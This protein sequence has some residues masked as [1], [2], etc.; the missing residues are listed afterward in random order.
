ME[1]IEPVEEVLLNDY[2]VGN[3][4][5]SVTTYQDLQNAANVKPYLKYYIDRISVASKCEFWKKTYILIINDNGNTSQQCMYDGKYRF[6]FMNDLSLQRELDYLKATS[7]EVLNQMH[8][9]EFCIEDRR[10]RRNVND[11]IEY[12][13]KIAN[14]ID[15]MFDIYKN[16][17]I[18]KFVDYNNNFVS[19]IYL[20]T[21]QNLTSKAIKKILNLNIVAIVNFSSSGRTLNDDFLQSLTNLEEIGILKKNNPQ[22]N[23]DEAVV[24]FLQQVN[25][26]SLIVNFLE[27]KFTYSQQVFRNLLTVSE[28]KNLKLRLNYHSPLRALL[29]EKSTSGSDIPYNFFHSIIELRISFAK[30]TTF[31]AYL[32]EFPNLETLGMIIELHSQCKIKLKKITRKGFLERHHNMDN[33]VNL[34]KLKEVTIFVADVKLNEKKEVAD[35]YQIL[36][37]YIL[38]NLPKEIKRLWIS[39]SGCLTNEMM[40][41][42]RTRHQLLEA[43]S[44][45]NVRFAKYDCLVDLNSLKFLHLVGTER[46]QIPENVEHLIVE[47][48]AERFNYNL[49]NNN[50]AIKTWNVDETTFPSLRNYIFMKIDLEIRVNIYFKSIKSLCFGQKMIQKAQKN[51]NWKDFFEF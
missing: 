49:K 48:E 39:Y 32:S 21:I 26:K 44:L 40:T 20:D 37:T 3:I 12:G 22:S 38:R 33:V 17:S 9:I 25:I 14:F 42:I 36:L 1:Q 5:K 24:S 27:F 13:R 35:V 23:N 29:R 47:Y 4:M 43:L 45:R 51:W 34:T 7:S 18:L 8:E 31:N 30:M 46:V 41:S 16:S 15:S 28:R 2:L 50:K 6:L 19:S 11:T 10:T